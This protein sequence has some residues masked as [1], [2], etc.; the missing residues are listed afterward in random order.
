MLRCHLFLLLLLPLFGRAQAVATLSPA[1]PARLTDSLTVTFDAT[2][3]DQGLADWA[4]DVYAYTGVL[5]PASTSLTDWQHVQSGWSEAPARLR[6]QALGQHRYRLTF[7]P[8]DFYQLAAGEQVLQFAFVFKNAD[9]SHSGR[10]AGGA[11]VLLPLYAASSRAYAYHRWQG[12]QL[13]VVGTDSSRLTVQPWAGGVARVAVYPAGVAAV[14]T[15][16]LAVSAAPTATGATLAVSATRLTIA[17]PGL[18]VEIDKNPLRL[19]YL[20][21]PQDTVL[22]EAPGYVEVS[23][24][25]AVR[26]ALNATEAL[27]GTGSRA[28][29]TNR[30]GQRVALYNQAHYGYQNGE[31]NLNISIPLVLGGRGFGVLLDEV[32]PGYIDLGQSDNTALEIGTEAN[33]LTYF[34]FAQKT[35]PALLAAYTDLTGHQP[36]PPRWALGYLQS[37]YGY[38]TEAEARS[39]VQR[40]REAGFPLSGLVLDLYWFGDKQLMGNLDWDRSRFANAEGM[41]TDF[42][43]LGVKTILIAEPYVTQQSRNYA[44]L[45]ASGL[46]ARTSAGAPYVLGGFWAGSAGLLDVTNPAARAWLWPWY[47]ARAQQGVGGWWSDLGEPETHPDDM[48]HAGGTAR[49]VHNGFANQWATVLQ[50]GYAQD[51]PQQR[52]F[53][54]GRA[55]FAGMQRLGITPWSG[56]VQRS[57]S[58]LQAQLPIMLGMGLS[59]EGYMHS[60]AGGFTG[61]G[62]DNELYTRWLQFAAFSPIMRAHGTSTTAPTDYPQPYQGIV[63]DYARLRQRLLPYTYTLAWENSQTGAPLARPTNYLAA[64]DDSYLWGSDLLV[65]PVLNAGQTQRTVALPAGGEWVDYWTGSRYA[66]GSLAT[67]A[68]PLARLPL[69]VRAGA[70][71]PTQPYRP[72]AALGVLDSLQITYYPAATASTGQVY[73]DDGRTPHAYALGQYQLLQFAA[74]PTSATDYALTATA[75][76]AGYAGGPARRVL[77]FVVPG[78][79]APGSVQLQGQPLPLSATPAAYAAA[80]SGAYYDAATRRL[81]VRLRWRHQPVQVQVRGLALAA[82]PAAALPAVALNAPYPNPF[83]GSTTLSCELARPGRYALRLYDLSGRLL[84]EWPLEAAAPGTQAVQWAGDDALGRPLP[85]GVYVL[86]LNGQHQRVTVV[87][88]L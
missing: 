46:L 23:G 63:R 55:G 73:D 60:D 34:V 3:G 78:V 69:L 16:S 12:G 54:L 83:A 2:R 29:P 35:L 18:S 43:A 38:Q 68:A 64:S 9:G 36:L 77:E 85:T 47:K 32:Q 82:T 21:G 8:I 11:D 48:V 49:Q 10:N 59:G 81:Q 41:M 42:N 70:L 44:S 28:V 24:L 30:R 84:R 56:D 74:S 87:R 25:R 88:E 58:G 72:S 33:Q 26:F 15:P 13:T 20:R 27:Y 65:A 5:T 52:L 50:N 1:R 7:K 57:W 80:D 39:I 51:F 22:A 76:G 40:L 53:N 66:G 31:T 62:Q 79:A 17:G 45:A 37:K 86:E 71:L 4:G 67:V 75:S 14:P 61:G 6:M 19:R